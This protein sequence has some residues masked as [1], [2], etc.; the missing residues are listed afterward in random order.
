[1]SKTVTVPAG[2]HRQSRFFA[3]TA[4]LWRR[5]GNLE[6]SVLEDELEGVRIE[7]P[8]YVTSLARAGT[9]IVT[10]MLE[11]HPAVT[12]HRFWLEDQLAAT[13]LCL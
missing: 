6:S 4:G 2:L 1:M 8:L 13:T 3:S 12:S 9:T 10:E 5:L 11:R 7:R